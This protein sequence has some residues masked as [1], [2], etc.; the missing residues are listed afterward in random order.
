M[1]NLIKVLRKITEEENYKIISSIDLTKNPS[2]DNKKEFIK[3][4]RTGNKV[5]LF[6]IFPW[7]DPEISIVSVK[8]G[9]DVILYNGTKLSAINLND[10]WSKI[11]KIK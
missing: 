9:E 4:L 7:K 2:E 5:K 10:L 8:K 3:K 11:E 6:S 1:Y